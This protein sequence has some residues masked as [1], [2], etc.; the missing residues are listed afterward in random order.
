MFVPECARDGDVGDDPSRL[1]PVAVDGVELAANKVQV[2]VEVLVPHARLPH[3]NRAHASSATRFDRCDGLEAW[4]VVGA[5]LLQ[6]LLGERPTH[7]HDVLQSGYTHK[8]KYK[9]KSDLR[10]LVGLPSLVAVLPSC[11]AV[12]PD[13][14]ELVVVPAGE[15]HLVGVH[16]EHGGRRTP[17]I[18]ASALRPT[19]DTSALG[20]KKAKSRFLPGLNQLSGS[21]AAGCGDL[22]VVCSRG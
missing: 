19:Q 11:P 1:L 6:E 15:E 13:L 2:G 8:H 21:H 5:Y 17:H 20:P 12:W 18:H 4:R 22:P 16:L 14:E 9:Y 10:G 7:G 3:H